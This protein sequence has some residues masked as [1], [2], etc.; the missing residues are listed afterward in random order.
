MRFPLLFSA[1]LIFCTSIQTTFKG[2]IPHTFM[3]S[4]MFPPGTLPTDAF[5]F[6]YRVNERASY[7]PIAK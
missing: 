7:Y 5:A 4:F 2:F 6:E 3:A 1:R